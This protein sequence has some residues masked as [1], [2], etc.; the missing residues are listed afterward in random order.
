MFLRRC[1]SQAR[2]ITRG[3]ASASHEGNCV[4]VHRGATIAPSAQLS[5]QVAE[6]QIT[7]KVGQETTA[8]NQDVA[9]TLWMAVPETT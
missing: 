9:E 2:V 5:D 6:A 3:E 4:V 1:R 7:S 8:S